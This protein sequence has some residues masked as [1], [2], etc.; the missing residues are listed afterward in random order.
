MIFKSKKVSIAALGIVAL[1]FSR[2]LFSL[3]NDPEGPNLL[4]VLV[5]AFILYLASLVA[6]IH[7][8]S[9]NAAKRFWSAIVIQLVLVTVLYILG[10]WL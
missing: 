7:I 8:P 3:F 6:Y 10:L 2:V 9:A 1:V 4:I 5:L